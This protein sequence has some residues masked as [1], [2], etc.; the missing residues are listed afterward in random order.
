M[1][2]PAALSRAWCRCPHADVPRHAVLQAAWCP[3]H[4]HD[5]GRAENGCNEIA[6]ESE[7]QALLDIHLLFQT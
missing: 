1:I 6:F 4:R 7:Q 2:Y 3:T 5:V